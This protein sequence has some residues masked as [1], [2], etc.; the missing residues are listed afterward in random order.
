MPMVSGLCLVQSNRVSKMKTIKQV[1]QT[2]V[3]NMP[4]HKQAQA[5]A[6]KELQERMGIFPK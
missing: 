3:Q 5:Q 1:I 4:A 6:R 2:I